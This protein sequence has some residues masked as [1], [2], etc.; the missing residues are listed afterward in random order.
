M[1]K[2]TKRQIQEWF[3]KFNKQYYKGRLFRW[4]VIIGAHPSRAASAGYCD[5]DTKTIFVPE[6]VLETEEKTLD[7]LLHEMTHIRIKPHGPRFVNEMERLKS[8]GAPI[9]DYEMDITR[10]IYSNSGSAMVGLD[11]IAIKIN[12]DYVHGS[13][14]DA[15]LEGLTL[16]ESQRAVAWDIG[17]S[18]EGLIRRWAR[19]SKGS[20]SP[21]VLKKRGGQYPYDLFHARIMAVEL[22]NQGKSL[23]EIAGELKKA[24]YKPMRS[25][26]YTSSSVWHL[27]YMD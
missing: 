27:L 8:F 13:I 3:N 5:H 24:G 18:L 21:D 4:N 16:E 25:E 6:R 23:R 11:G 7:L 9:S 20:G 1:A 14:D 10:K 12:A 2:I 22:R 26:W 15:M 17:F 19:A